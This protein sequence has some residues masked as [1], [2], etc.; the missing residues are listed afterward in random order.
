MK[1]CFAIAAATLVAAH[2]STATAEDCRSELQPKSQ[3][4]SH[5]GRVVQVIDGDTIRLDTGPEVRMMG[6]QA[7][8]LPLGRPGFKPWP[9]STEARSLLEN[10]TQ[11]QSVQLFFGPTDTDRYGRALAHVFLE[12]ENGAPTI[13][14]QGEMVRR[15]MARV[16]VLVDNRVCVAP[17][18]A[19]EKAARQER[20]GIWSLPFYRIRSHDKADEDVGTFQIVEGVVQ[21]VAKRRSRYF[22]NFGQDWREDFTITISPDYAR[23]FEKE[24]DPHTYEGKKVRVRGWVEDYNGPFIEASHPDQIEITPEAASIWPF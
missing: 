12:D 14:L 5:T 17:L 15:G 16:Y 7:P 24:V 9:L 10:L 21:D 6:T 1:A 23:K 11:D 13:W 22:L 20:R 2:I 18:L 3:T 8:K 19:R 4:H